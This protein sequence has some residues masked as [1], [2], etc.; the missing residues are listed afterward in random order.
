[1]RHHVVVSLAAGSDYPRR[2]MSPPPPRTLLALA[3]LMLGAC[4]PGSSEGGGATTSGAE[5]TVAEHTNAPPPEA[6]PE[7]ET[8]P[9]SGG[10]LHPGRTGSGRSAEDPVSACGPGDSYAFVASEFRCP[11][12]DN[13]LG[14]DPS[15]G[16]NARVGNVGA[17]STGH[18]IDHY[19]V[20]C[21]SGPVDVYVDMY[22]CPEM[23]NLFGE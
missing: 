11:E 9:P 12:G 2:E 1:V 7:T 4:G 22:G 23:Q 10:G 3:A 15:A 20:P 21:A 8:P 13:P 14:G 19:R 17:N 5:M 6:P 18:I 16:A